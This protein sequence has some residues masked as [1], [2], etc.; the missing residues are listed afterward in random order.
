MTVKKLLDRL[1][2]AEKQIDSD[3]EAILKILETEI[4]DLNR[5]EQLFKK[6][7]GTDGKLLGVYSKAT[8]DIT[9]GRQGVGFPKRAGSPYNL[10]NT[11][12]M[13]KSFALRPGKDSFSIIN[14][15]SSIKEF[16]KS[17]GIPTERIIGLTE[18]N[19]KTVELKRVL[20]LL[21]EFFKRN[22][23]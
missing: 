15:S 23:N 2:R 19:S 13:F 21:R 11:G 16:S 4:L 22:L 7:I 9:E 3:F 17:K 5:D 12:E 20:P 14:T 8:E 6:G 10:F 18:I 1:I